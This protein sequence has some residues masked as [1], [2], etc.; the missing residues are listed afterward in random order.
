M[1]DFAEFVHTFSDWVDIEEDE[2]DLT[3][4]PTPRPRIPAAV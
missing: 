3:P 1:I 4:A 2:A